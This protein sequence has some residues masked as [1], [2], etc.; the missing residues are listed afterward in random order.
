MINRRTFLF[1]SSLAPL[2]SFI[3]FPSTSLA[4]NVQYLGTNPNQLDNE[5]DTRLVIQGWHEEGSDLSKVQLINLS[6][7]WKSSWL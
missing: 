1:L 6:S 4:T 2:A 3:T 7:T 5:K